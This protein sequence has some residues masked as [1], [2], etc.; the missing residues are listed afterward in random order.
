MRTRFFRALL[1]TICTFLAIKDSAHIDAYR[2]RIDSAISQIVSPC[3]RT[4]RPKLA[5]TKFH[6]SFVT[7]TLFSCVIMG[8]FSVFEKTIRKRWSPFAHWHSPFAHWHSSLFTDCLR[9][10]I[11]IGAKSKKGSFYW[12]SQCT[13]CYVI[14]SPSGNRSFSWQ[15]QCA[16]W[17]V[18]K[19]PF[20]NR[21]GCMQ[22]MRQRW[23][24]TQTQCARWKRTYMCPFSIRRMRNL[25]SVDLQTERKRVPDNAR[26]E[27]KVTKTGHFGKMR[28]WGFEKNASMGITMRG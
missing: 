16:H 13:H 21:S 14:E 10:D 8:E 18:I 22:Q 23:E 2:L 4:V 17:Y 15:S 24:T 25:F 20:R 26:K 7:M 27:T 28:I 19:S 1:L 12:Q 5:D 3:L 6:Q 9:I 11:T